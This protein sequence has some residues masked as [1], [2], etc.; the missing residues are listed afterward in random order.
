ML[1][2]VGEHLWGQVEPEKVKMVSL[3]AG[4]LASTHEETCGA[5]CAGVMILGALYGRS[6]P[7]G[8][9]TLAKQLAQKLREG[10][11]AEYGSTQC[12][13][14]R[15]LVKGPDNS[16]SCAP[17]GELGAA[18]LLALLDKVEQHEEL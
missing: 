3:F 17:V 4:G 13:R 7:D 11:V 14:V 15:E 2:A 8:D 9:E 10:F 1:L 5:L 16:G 6:G 18:L 12:K